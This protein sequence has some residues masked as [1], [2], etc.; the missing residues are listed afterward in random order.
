MDLTIKSEKQKYPLGKTLRRMTRNILER[1]KTL[2]VPFAIYT[3]AAA[4]YPA[5]AAVLP[6]LMIGEMLVAE[7]SISGIVWILGIYLAAVA[8]V[9]FTKD[10]S[11]GGAYVRISR[12][13][14]DYMRDQVKVMMS[15]D[16]K[17]TEDAEWMNQNERALNACNTNEQGMEGT[18]HRLFETPAVFI[19]VLGFTVVI[20]LQSPWILLGLVLNIAAVI[21][22]GRA[23]HNFR[24]KN[25]AKFAKSSR[26]LYY[27]NQTSADFAYGKD[28]RIYN[29]K[30]RI[31][32]NF[33]HEIEVFTDIQK[34]FQNREF[35][36][37]FL[38]LATLLVSNALTYGILIYKVI[39]GM[40]ID[41]FSMYIAMVTSASILLKTV[42]DN[43][44]QI[45]NE[46]Q[47]VHDFYELVDENKKP[48]GGERPKIENDT[49][50]IE[51]RNVSFKYPRTEKWIF[52]NLSLKIEKG[53]RLAVVGING[54]GKTT[55]VKLI[56]GLFEPD[57]GEILINGFPL[58]S[59]QRQAVFDMYSAVFQDVNIFAFSILENVACDGGEID[60]SRAMEALER[61]GLGDKV[62]SFER[63]MLQPLLKII[64]E[65]GVEL[66]GGENQKIS[67][68]R[69]LYKNA[70]MII[71]DEPTAALDALAEAEIYEKFSDLVSGKTALYISHRLASTKF[72]DKI[73]FFDGSGLAEYGNHAELMALSGKY[74]EMFDIQGKYYR[75]GLESG[76]ADEGRGLA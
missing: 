63:G 32:G 50:E 36:L 56:C 52:E 17:N 11:F 29:L 68:A 53:E 24:Y 61:A 31:L 64:D 16:Y 72:C 70:N 39:S 66:S 37:G 21:W 47:Y 4:I 55:L 46:G 75:E 23:A 73:A 38:G 1:D 49:L 12:L 2:F 48:A 13:R 8:I 42:A 51:L 59:Y 28:V 22:I 10:F 58:K 43:L 6:K 41:D 74:R 15:M 9:G 45:I 57:G 33:L 25:R 5:F 65:T 20:G 34:M 69:A 44:T 3:V 67:I 26:R 54:A 27:Y 30:N 62:R 14:L 18:Y 19:T 60:E 76:E 71:M 7:P 40:G 35:F